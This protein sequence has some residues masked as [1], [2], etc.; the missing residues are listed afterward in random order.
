MVDKGNVSYD[1][2]TNTVV[3]NATANPKLDRIVHQNDSIRKLPNIE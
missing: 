1:S 3:A 2:A